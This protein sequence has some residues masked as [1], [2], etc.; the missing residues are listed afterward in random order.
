MHGLK[1]ENMIHSCWTYN[2]LVFIKHKE[3]DMPANS[4]NNLKMIS[5]EL[6]DF[7]F[8]LV[9]NASVKENCNFDFN[10]DPNCNFFV[11]IDNKDVYNN[12]K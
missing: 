7:D 8:S 3:G 12:N 2:G 6:E 1:K 9:N 10:F 5:T 11:T 4:F